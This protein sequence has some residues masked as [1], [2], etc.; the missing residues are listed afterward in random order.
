MMVH[1]C[2]QAP[3]SVQGKQI[4]RPDTLAKEPGEQQLQ[5]DW[6]TTGL[7][8]PGAQ[9]L[10]LDVPMMEW[11]PAG[12]TVN[13]STVFEAAPFET[14]KCIRNQTSST[15]NQYQFQKSI[16]FPHTPTP[17]INNFNTCYA[18]TPPANIASPSFGSDAAA[19]YARATLR[20]AV[21]HI[22]LVALKMS[23]V[24]K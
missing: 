13:V 20:A 5:E 9:R 14:E 19:R 11:E 18:P 22:P 1:G 3:D 12:H 16:S 4:E 8:D 17:A 23:T 6:P 21:V 15:R 24:L 2:W 7:K 10:H